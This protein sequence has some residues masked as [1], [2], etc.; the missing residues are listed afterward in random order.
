M[1]VLWKS[2]GRM[3]SH[4]ILWK[5]I[6]MFETTNQFML[7]NENY[8]C[9]EFCSCLV[10]AKT[11]PHTNVKDRIFSADFPVFQNDSPWKLVTSRV[12]S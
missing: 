11:G 8:S 3:T 1:K 5:M 6:Q 10:L 9:R 2:M 12:T 7:A 4:I